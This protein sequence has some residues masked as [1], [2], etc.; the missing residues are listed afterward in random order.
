MPW[1][2][3]AISQ[4]VITLQNHSYSLS[5]QFDYEMPNPAINERLVEERNVPGT[6]FTLQVWCSDATTDLKEFAN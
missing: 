4:D 6:L 2:S 1:A 3:V 5:T